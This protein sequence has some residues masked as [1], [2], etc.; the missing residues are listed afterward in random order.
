MNGIYAQGKYPLQIGNLWQYRNSFDSTYGWTERT[1]RDTLFQNG[2]IFTVIEN[3]NK[4]E[5]FVRQEG[6]KVLFMNKYPNSDTSYEYTER[7]YYDFSKTIGDTVEVFVQKYPVDTL[8]IKVKYDLLLNVFGTMR[9]TWVYVEKSKRVSAYTEWWVSDSIGIIRIE[10]EAGT[11]YSL[12]GAK[13][14]GIN[15]GLIS[16][17]NNN[18][19]HLPNTFWV[20]QNYPNPFNPSTNISFTIPSKIFVSVRIYNILGKQIRVLLNGELVSG[21]YKVEWDG[22]N[23]YGEVV[24]SG[25]YFYQVFTND[26]QQTKKMILIR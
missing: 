12:Y 1:T 7:L 15:Y 6:S 11:A 16:H 5:G 26:Y 22:K 24:Q 8:I 18:L 13:I 2:I 21:Y 3:D 20:D 25:V 23:D 19:I 17:A 4:S 14:N 10:G 9:H